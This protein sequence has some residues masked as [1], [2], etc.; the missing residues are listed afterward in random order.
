MLTSQRDRHI[1]KITPLMKLLKGIL[2]KLGS[3]AYILIFFQL[4]RILESLRQLHSLAYT[5]N[6]TILVSHKVVKIL[7]SKSMKY[8]SIFPTALQDYNSAGY[9]KL[10]VASIR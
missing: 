9:F 5:L 10:Y 8:C 2:A 1:G 6:Y 4:G 7:V 3:Q